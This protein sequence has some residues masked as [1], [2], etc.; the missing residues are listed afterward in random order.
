MFGGSEFAR[1]IPSPV[2]SFNTPRLWA[3]TPPLWTSTPPLWGWAS[4]AP[5]WASTAHNYLTLMRIQIGFFSGSMRIRIRVRN[6]EACVIW[7]KLKDGRECNC[8][9]MKGK[10]TV[11]NDLWVYIS[12]PPLKK[13]SKQTVV[14]C[15]TSLL[16]VPLSLLI[17]QIWLVTY[18]TII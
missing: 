1:R 3:S 8:V 14:L 10:T 7:K 4:L 2:K 15:S 12:Q 13:R 11:K 17:W 6:T 9:C 16:K 5:F 18:I